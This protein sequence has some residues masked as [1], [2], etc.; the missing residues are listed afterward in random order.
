VTVVQFRGTEDTL[1]PYEGGNA[2]SGAQNN[3][4]TWGE[5][6]TCSGAAMSHEANT[7]CESYPTCD[8]GVET[9]LCTV[10]GG[11]HCGSY[12][13]FMIPQLAWEVL[14]QHTLP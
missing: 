3:F 5:I 11:T 2:F 8:A 4:A 1:V 12:R 6:N 9:L 10:E 7:A 14:Q 13:S